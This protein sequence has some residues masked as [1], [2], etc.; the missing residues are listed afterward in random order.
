MV[1]PTSLVAGKHRL[2]SRTGRNHQHKVFATSSADFSDEQLKG[3]LE[4]Q[5][6]KSSQNA[7]P[8]NPAPSSDLSADVADDLQQRQRE[9]RAWIT[10][11]LESKLAEKSVVTQA[12]LR[13][14]VSLMSVDEEQL[15]LKRLLFGGSMDEIL[16]EEQ[17]QAEQPAQ[18]DAKGAPEEEAK[19]EEVQ[20][21]STKVKKPKRPRA[22]APAAAAAASATPAAAS[23]DAQAPPTAPHAYEDGTLLF[24]YEMLQAV[25]FEDTLTA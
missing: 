13:E 8:A 5:L 2:A 11:W 16:A 22:A 12:Q 4:R 20:V 24:T 10:P 17:P 21:G 19:E 18:P 9:A 25:S 23:A 15:A 14:R 7:A 3:A 1:L 6:K